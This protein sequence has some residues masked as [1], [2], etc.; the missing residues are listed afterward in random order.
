MSYSDCQQYVKIRCPIIVTRQ[1]G[2]T[3]CSQIPSNRVCGTALSALSTER[4]CSYLCV[5]PAASTQSPDGHAASRKLSKQLRHARRSFTVAR[6]DYRPFQVLSKLFWPNLPL[7][8]RRGFCLTDLDDGPVPHQRQC[9]GF[10]GCRP[11]QNEVVVSV[12]QDA[13]HSFS[14]L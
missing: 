11:G 9:G 7:A 2:L 6:D 8:E 12:D 4:R 1:G 5:S 14:S 10:V 3:V 13:D